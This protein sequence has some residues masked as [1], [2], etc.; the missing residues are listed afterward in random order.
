MTQI[1]RMY[2]LLLECDNKFPIDVITLAEIKKDYAAKLSRWQQQEQTLNIG[3]MG[4]VKAGKSTFLNALLFDG[5]PILPE[6]A[7]PKTANLTKVVYGERHS[8]QVEYYSQQEWD[9]IV[10]QANQAGEGDA[11]KVARELVTMVQASGI[12]LTLHWQR[13][14]GEEHCDTFYA[15]DVAGLQGLLNQYAGNDGRYTAL[16]K[17]T[18]LTLPDESL[19]G[20][21]VVDTPGMND[22]VQSRSQK[23]RDYMA[24]CDVVFFLSRCSQFLDESDVRLLSE[25]LPGKGVKRLVLVAGQFDS[26]LLDDG[27]DR[28]SLAETEANIRRRL[29]RG[30][31]EKVNELVKQRRERGQDRLAEVLTQLAEPVFASTFAYGFANWPEEKW[32]NSMRHTHGQLQEMA[33]ECWDEPITPAQWLRLANFDA[34]TGAYQQARRDREPLLKQQ[35]EGLEQETEERLSQWRDNFALRVTQRMT[36]LKTQDLQSLEKQ[37]QGCDKR[38]SAIANE[39]RTLI[40]GVKTK[41]QQDSSAMLGQLDSDRG[42]FSR[43]QT[44][45][46]THEEE[47]YRTVSDSTWYKPWTWGDTRREYYTRTVSYDYLSASDAIEQVRDY[48]HQCAEQMRNHIN[49]LISPLELKNSLRKALLK[50]LDTGNEHFNPALFKGTLEGAINRLALPTLELSLGDATAIIPFS[51]ELKEQG[52]MNRLRSYLDQALSNVFAQLETRLKKGVT[53]VVAQLDHLQTS[54]QNDL[55][56][57]IQNELELVRQ[58][59]QHKEQELANYDQLL[60][61]LGTM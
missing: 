51:G 19:K 43:L 40:E 15:D 53:E 54:I 9:E 33:E 29:Q 22:P 17:S 41:A 28:T 44:R 20:F 25:Q 45:T 34:L 52:E 35:R 55:T 11:S 32:G 58:G 1:E 13:I 30:A 36:L 59:L 38:L 2:M 7:T 8:L 14:G 61:R 47:R 21:E 39:L 24:N 42:R 18:V 37:Q 3:I 4:Q 16:V 57:D 50:H 23:T 12:D 49:R 26:T 60:T 27:Y 31:S 48:G 56:Q 10:G 5:R 46:A 6:A